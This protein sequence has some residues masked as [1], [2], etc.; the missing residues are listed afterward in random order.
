VPDGIECAEPILAPS[1][2]RLTSA[3]AK[4]RLHHIQTDLKEGP[5]VATTTG[6]AFTSS[7][8]RM[9]SRFSYFVKARL[10]DY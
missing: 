8:V 1:R 7:L 2:H 6:T 5:T 4:S 9:S 3:L 10:H